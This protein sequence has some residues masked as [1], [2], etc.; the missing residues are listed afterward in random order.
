MIKVVHKTKVKCHTNT[1]DT[2]RTKLC[3]VIFDK[4]TK[5]AQEK[6]KRESVYAVKKQTDP[7]WLLQRLQHYCT[8]Y[9]GNR[10]LPAVHLNA[11][12]GIATIKQGEHKSVTNFTERVKTRV[13]T[14]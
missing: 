12:N 14:Y 11:L 7:A 3:G 8:S 10:H 1:L 4:I 9:K 5:G 6:L 13:T 2:H